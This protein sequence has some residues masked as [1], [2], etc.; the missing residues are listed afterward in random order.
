MDFALEAQV[1]NE[2]PGYTAA[3]R[4]L[5]SNEEKILRGGHG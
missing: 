1:E 2:Y 5:F 3:L 4:K